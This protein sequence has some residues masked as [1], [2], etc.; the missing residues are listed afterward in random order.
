MSLRK[1]Y[2]PQKRFLVDMVMKYKNRLIKLIS[3]CITKVSSYHIH[4]IHTIPQT[5]SQHFN[6]YTLAP[7]Q[8]VN[9]PPA[10]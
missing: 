5:L 3:H 1:A 2:V 9:S 8:E 7:F 6:F 4:V 10:I